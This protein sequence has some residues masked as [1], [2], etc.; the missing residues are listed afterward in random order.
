MGSRD[1]VVGFSRNSLSLGQKFPEI[2]NRWT[3]LLVTYA[4]TLVIRP[5]PNL[6]VSMWTISVFLSFVLLNRR[7]MAGLFHRHIKQS[8]VFPF[9][10]HVKSSAKQFSAVFRTSF[11]N[12]FVCRYNPV[13]SL[14]LRLDFF[15]MRRAGWRKEPSLH[16]DT[17]CVSACVNRHVRYFWLCVP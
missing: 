3:S 6:R 2:R 15:F 17:V 11:S 1:M 9:C 12:P 13:A 10:L 14:T 4:S 8:N 5:T 7:S 16:F